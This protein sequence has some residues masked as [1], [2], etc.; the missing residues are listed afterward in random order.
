MLR[1]SLASLMSTNASVRAS[2][3]VV[4]ATQ[5]NSS[6]PVLR[7]GHI[8]GLNR[9]GL[10]PNNPQQI[11]GLSSNFLSFGLG[12]S[13]PCFFIFRA[14]PEFPLQVRRQVLNLRLAM[15]DW[16]F[17]SLPCGAGDPRLRRRLI[18]AVL[19]KSSAPDRCHCSDCSNHRKLTHSV[20]PQPELLNQRIGS[21]WVPDIPT[22]SRLLHRD[23]PTTGTPALRARRERPCRRRPAEKRDELAPF[24][25]ASPEAS[26]ARCKIA[27][28]Q[29]QVRGIRAFQTR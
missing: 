7:I 15:T 26:G 13:F 8:P 2:P 5:P 9:A 1:R 23:T 20:A 6:R 14:R 10:D 27:N 18:A 16:R 22:A 19:R 11:F 21:R 3:S 24:H 25:V 28:F 17:R 12:W 29:G 4:G